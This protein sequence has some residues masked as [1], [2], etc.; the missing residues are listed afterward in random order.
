M[1]ITRAWDETAPAD[2][3][4]AN[5]LGQDIRFAKQDLRE[6]MEDTLVNPGTW[7]ASG[8]GVDPVIRP[9][10]LGN[11]VTKKMIF[12]WSTFRV[13]PIGFAG[14]FGISPTYSA[15]NTNYA[16]VAAGS[17]AATARANV[18]LAAGAIIT[19]V[20]FTS[21]K[22]GGNQ[23]TM[24]LQ[25]LTFESNPGGAPV[26]IAGALG[27]A[28]NGVF[29]SPS[30][31]IAETVPGANANAYVIEVNFNANNRFYGAEIIYST[32]DSTCLV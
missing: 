27:F 9:A 12:H 28:I 24:N 32:I 17:G 7:S 20:S 5:L 2:N 23:L 1:A 16:Q 25:R 19:Q 6:R 14:G 15:T 29:S 3:T 11:V 22:N 10:V 18:I 4:L 8:P 30:A 13:D 21:D 26:A 31:V